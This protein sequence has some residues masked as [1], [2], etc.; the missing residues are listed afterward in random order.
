MSAQKS[1]QG[2]ESEM[3]E[4]QRGTDKNSISPT[5]GFFVQTE[6]IELVAGPGD[7]LTAPRS[8][9]RRRV[10][11]PRRRVTEELREESP[12]PLEL[13]TLPKACLNF[14]LNLECCVM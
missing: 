11:E 10:T 3:R 5:R 4:L 7:K 14:F 12:P 9:L 8:K 13:R 6:K 1:L 2:F